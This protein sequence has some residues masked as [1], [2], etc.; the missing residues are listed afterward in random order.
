MADTIVGYDEQN[1]GRGPSQ[2]LQLPGI[3]LAGLG[4]NAPPSLR[5]SIISPTPGAR[6]DRLGMKQELV[7][8]AQRKTV[9]ELYQKTIRPRG[10]RRVGKF[11]PSPGTDRRLSGEGRVRAE[12]PAKLHR[13]GPSFLSGIF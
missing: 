4:R 8:G 11:L 10:N 1:R 9:V 12:A 6:L 2:R 7:L 3:Q 5:L 13:K